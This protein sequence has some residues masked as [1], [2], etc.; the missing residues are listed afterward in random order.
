LLKLVDTDELRHIELDLREKLF[1]LYITSEIEGAMDFDLLKSLLLNND[2]LQ[3]GLVVVVTWLALL[4]S[5]V[6]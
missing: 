2:R 5:L 6:S 4:S 1:L 3:Y